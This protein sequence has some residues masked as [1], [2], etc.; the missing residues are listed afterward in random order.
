MATDTDLWGDEP[1]ATEDSGGLQDGDI[2][3]PTTGEIVDPTDADSLIDSFDRLKKQ[4]DK[5]CQ[6]KDTVRDRLVAMTTGDAKT[7]RVAGKRR[8]VAVE[9]PSDNYDNSILKEAW[10][11]YPGLRDEYLRVERIA[12]KLRGEE[13]VRHQRAAGSDEFPGDDRAGQQWADRK[14]LRENRT[15]VNRSDP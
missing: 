6:I 9:M 7:R 14:C 4:I 10:N 15:V 2:V 13:A 3:D 8:R 5:L 12:P 1:A 11:S